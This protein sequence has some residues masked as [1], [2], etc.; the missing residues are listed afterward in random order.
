MNPKDLRENEIKN[1]FRLKITEHQEPKISFG[2]LREGSIF[3]VYLSND[4]YIKLDAQ[5]D[6]GNTVDL[7]TGEVVDYLSGTLVHPLKAR[8][9]IE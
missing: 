3:S 6:F 4:Y 8:M 5:T 1:D 9:I 2:D 7:V